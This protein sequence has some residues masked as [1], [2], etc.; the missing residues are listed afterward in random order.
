MKTTR[1]SK[2]H[3]YDECADIVHKYGMESNRNRNEAVEVVNKVCEVLG[4]HGFIDSDWWAENEK[5]KD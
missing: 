2:K 3:W 5:I 1:H 4:R